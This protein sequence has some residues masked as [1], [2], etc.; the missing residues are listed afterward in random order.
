MPVLLF[1][2]EALGASTPYRAA[3]SCEYRCGQIWLLYKFVNLQWLL[4]S[5]IV[6]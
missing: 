2:N 4:N 3:Y 5:I 6:R 1:F